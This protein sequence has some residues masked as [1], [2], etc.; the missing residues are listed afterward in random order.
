M[1][2]GCG[3]VL[4]KKNKAIKKSKIKIDPVSTF[5]NCVGNV[6][7]VSCKPGRVFDKG[8]KGV[9]NGVIKVSHFLRHLL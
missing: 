7:H 8:S 5:T 3:K 1:T 2:P 6:C 4:D 9:V